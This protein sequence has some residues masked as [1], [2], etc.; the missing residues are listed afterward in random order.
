MTSSHQC[1]GVQLSL[2][3]PVFEWTLAADFIESLTAAD[4]GEPERAWEVEI[5]RREAELDQG[6][7][8]TVDWSMVR[9]SVLDGDTDGSGDG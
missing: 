4:A 7:V 3:L 8:E 5:A 2:A 9:R 6:E 1:C